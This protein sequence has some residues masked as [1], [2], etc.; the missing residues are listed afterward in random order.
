[1]K[2]NKVLLVKTELGAQ[3]NSTWS[4]YNGDILFCEKNETTQGETL[5]QQYFLKEIIYGFN[6]KQHLLK[7]NDNI[8]F[9][10]RVTSL[11]DGNNLIPM[12]ILLRDGLLEDITRDYK[13]EKILEK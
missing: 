13:I 6:G 10:K 9:W 7:L 3:L 2:Y 1:M 11:L 4:L 5:P 8:P 12:E